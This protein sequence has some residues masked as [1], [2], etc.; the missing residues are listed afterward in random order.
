VNEESRSG[1]GR[2]LP[3]GAFDAAADRDSGADGALFLALVVVLAALVRFIGL[4]AQS[5]WIDEY[6]TWRE[7][8]PAGGQGFWEQIS[9]TIQGPLYLAALWPLR[10]FADEFLLRLPA[11]LAGVATVPLVWML[12]RRLFDERSARLA[13][14]LVA[15]SPFHVWYSQEARGYAFL[16]LFA[17]IQSLLALRLMRRPVAGAGVAYGVVA[18]LSAASNFS[19]YFLLAGHVLAMLLLARPRDGRGWSA[20]ALAAG[21]PVLLTAP[22]LLRATGV[23][24]VDR[25]LPGAETGTALRGETTFTPLAYPFTFQAFFYGFSLG[26]SLAELHG[27]DR[28]LAIRQALPW[29]APA[30]LAAGAAFVAGLIRAGRGRAAMLA[31]WGLTPVILLTVLAVQNVKTFNPRYLAAVYV[32]VP[33]LTACGL[34]ALPRRLARA[35]GAVLLCLTLVALAN[36]HLDSRYAKA[37]VRGA[38]DWVA[39]R[40]A[41]Q[42][43]VVVPAVS[44]LFEHYWRGPAAV[45]GLWSAGTIASPAAARA[46]LDEAVGDAPR[47]WLVLARSWHQDPRDLLPAA[48][49]E[50]GPAGESHRF[51][52]VRILSCALPA[53]AAVEGAEH[54]S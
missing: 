19:G 51:P 12:G 7:L 31:I 42:D 27:P 24:A 26:P 34:H 40:A 9:D 3:S 15:V 6:M 14:L 52:G 5:L 46:A 30:W 8:F 53:A 45:D 37:D 43:V 39:D 47:V 32:L 33:L 11:A 50:L 17:V 41:P 10:P 18:A 23:L 21:L 29:L 35:T 22:W 49:A 16:I 4:G 13:A 20:W 44:G 25:L 28:L 54:G 2:W 1:K 36:H 38:A 48:L